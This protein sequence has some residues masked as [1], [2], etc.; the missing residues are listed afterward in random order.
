MERRAIVAFM[1]MTMVATTL[2]GCSFNMS[3]GLGA[4]KTAAEVIEK[5]E[6]K[7]TESNFNL[8]GKLSMEIGMDAEGMTVSVPID[9]DINMDMVGEAA[10]GDMAM[11][12]SFM[13][14]NLDYSAEMYI[15]GD[16]VYMYDEDLDYW[17][18][19]DSEF[20]SS[21]STVI[22]P[23]LFENAE[24][25]VDKK[26]KT[27]TINQSF[28][29]FMS[30]DNVEDTFGDFT[31]SATG[32]FS[33]D[34]DDI[35]D[36]FS[37]ASV[38]YVF[39][40]DYHL[41]SVSLDG[42]SYEDTI[43]EDGYTADLYMNIG[44]DFNFSKFGEISEDDVTVPKSVKKEAVDDEDGNAG[45]M[46]S[47]GAGDDNEGIVTTPVPDESMVS[48][49][50]VEPQAPV[51]PE[52]T[53][54]V[55]VQTGSDLYGSYKGVSLTTGPNNWASTFGADGWVFD[56][57]DG[58]YSFMSCVNSKYGDA[59]LYVYNKASSDTTKADIT[60]YGFYGYDM[61]VSWADTKPAMTFNGITWGAS[62]D[63]V[64][65]AY[66][67]PDYTYEGSM[68]HSYEYELSN[69]IT[70]S[71]NVYFDAGL[72]EVSLDVYNY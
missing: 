15:D 16:K 46:G 24:L 54:T 53:P 69:N 56:N 68:Y 36:A 31:D 44:F 18:V 28:G 55:N 32:M 10:H 29:D 23:K 64:L 61:D 48:D 65:S 52:S 67:T 19:S 72:Q 40:T 8:D 35:I 38:T 3:F 22:D 30:N 17:T 9:L 1:A 7:D 71:F 51:E 45:V 27:Y 59:T 42:C 33:M 11:S 70:M 13:G 43:K 5:Y 60:D 26:A 63:D 39:D 41:L 58:E 25:V 50:P 21:L 62:S 20:E 14:E 34:A 49:I 6:A 47:F 4:P 2:T 12:A 37:D 66:G 57:E